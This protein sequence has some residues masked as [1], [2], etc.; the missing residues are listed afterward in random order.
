MYTV[1]EDEEGNKLETFYLDC[2]VGNWTEGPYMLQRNG[3]YYFTYT[4][5]HF[6]S[7]SY[8]VNYAYADK[9]SDIFSSKSFP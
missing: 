3:N 6:L 8:R 2:L 5:T 7:A 9:D 4:G 1:K